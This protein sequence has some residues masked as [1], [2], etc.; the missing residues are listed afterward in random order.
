MRGTLDRIEDGQYAVILLEQLNQEIVLPV[1]RLPAGSGVGSWFG[2]TMESGEVMS[3]TLDEKI[4]S[5]KEDQ[6]S[7]LLQKLKNKSSGSKFKRE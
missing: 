5:E 3:I 4:S 2:I 6:A 1:E 7:E